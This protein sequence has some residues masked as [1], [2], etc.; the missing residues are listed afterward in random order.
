M[1][2][3]ELRNKIEA[4]WLFTSSFFPDPSIPVRF[5]NSLSKFRDGVAEARHISPENLTCDLLENVAH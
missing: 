5:W 2:K 1:K 3:A 4:F